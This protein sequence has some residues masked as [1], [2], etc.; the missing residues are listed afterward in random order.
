[1][2]LKKEI[3]NYI[4]TNT[5]WSIKH[6]ELNINL[7]IYIK[8]AYDLWN[9]SIANFD[10]LF[11]RVKNNNIGM[12]IHYNAIKKIEESCLCRAV[13]VFDYLD[14]RSINRLI[15]K[16]IPFI[17]KNKQIYMPFAFMQL[18]TDKLSLKVLNK[19]TDLTPDTDIILIGYLNNKLNSQMMIKDIATIINREIRATSIAL[20]ILESLEYIRLEK[21]G[22]KKIIHFIPK[23]NIYE[24]LK[25]NGKSPIKYKF[26][27]NSNILN[28]NSTKSGYSAISRFSRLI[29]NAIPTIAIDTKKLPKIEIANI[30]CEKEDA[31]YLVEIWNR[32]PSIFSIENTI[33]PLYILRLFKDEDDER[34]KYALEEIE[35]KIIERF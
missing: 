32:E 8:S 30:K 25:K 7:P 35:N 1:M 4:E 10:I 31:L 28:K 33:N 19:S 20:T 13:L 17:V 29:D 23:K 11:A 9:S 6:K 5:Q 34:T 26:Y 27:T 12:T 22:R 18:Q 21:V 15:S 2:K 14:S 3:F 24:Q 16:Q